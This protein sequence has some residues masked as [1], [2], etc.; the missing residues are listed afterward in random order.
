MTTA[1]IMAMLSSTTKHLRT[2]AKKGWSAG[3]K[4]AALN[5]PKRVKR[6]EARTE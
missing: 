5:S 4:Q 3:M 1:V 2:A 6:K